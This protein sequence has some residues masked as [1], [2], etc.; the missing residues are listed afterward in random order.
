MANDMLKLNTDSNLGIFGFCCKSIFYDRVMV[1][2]FVIS[3]MAAIQV[4]NNMSKLKSN[5]NLDFG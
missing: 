3:V 2:M 4:A 1:T 5:L